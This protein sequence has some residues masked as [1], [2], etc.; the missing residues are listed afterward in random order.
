MTKILSEMVVYIATPD[1]PNKKGIVIPKKVLDKL[2]DEQPTL[3]GRIGFPFGLFRDNCSTDGLGPDEPNN[4]H[5]ISDFYYDEFGNLCGVVRILDNEEGK[6][7]LNM[8]DSNNIG[9]R[10]AGFGKTR[11][12]SGTIYLDETFNIVSF[13]AVETKETY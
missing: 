6:K 8:Y 5:Y 7:L 10:G 9:F 12:K 1:V 2:V 11:I 13:C 3:Y 4:S